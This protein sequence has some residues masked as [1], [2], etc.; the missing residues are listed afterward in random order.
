M[1]ESALTTRSQRRASRQHPVSSWSMGIWCRHQVGSGLGER[2]AGLGQVT[3]VLSLDRAM[4][5]SEPLEGR[6][7]IQRESNP[8]INYSLIISSQKKGYSK[9]AKYNTNLY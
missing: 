6:L 8:N 3:A 2:W 5:P 7:G 1:R 4:G 9:S